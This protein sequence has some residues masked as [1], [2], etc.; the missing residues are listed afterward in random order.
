MFQFEPN[1][2]FQL[3]AVSVTLDLFTGQQAVPAGA[4][5]DPF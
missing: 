1:Q 4:Y 2:Q 3:D 5:S